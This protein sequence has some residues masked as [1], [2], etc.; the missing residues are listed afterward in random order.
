MDFAYIYNDD[1]YIYTQYIAII[2][3]DTSVGIPS[4]SQSQCG[5]VPCRTAAWAFSP[6]ATLGS[7]AWRPCCALLQL[8]P[9]TT[10]SNME[11]LVV[12]PKHQRTVEHK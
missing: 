9:E 3:N 12:K 6:V 10:G 11:N 4:K 2:D 7:R 8:S 1:I 5:K